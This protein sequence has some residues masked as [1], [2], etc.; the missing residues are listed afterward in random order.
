[1]KVTRNRGKERGAPRADSGGGL[2]QKRI[3]SRRISQ[4]IAAFEDG[5]GRIE[6]LGTTRV[7]RR[8][9]P[10]ADGDPP[11]DTGESSR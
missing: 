5:G 8:I 9:D 11:A 6:K 10:A 7:L 2:D 1:M 4:Q 3:E